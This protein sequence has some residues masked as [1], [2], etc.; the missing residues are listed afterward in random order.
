ME[1]I[2]AYSLHPV[3]GRD[4]LASLISQKMERPPPAPIQKFSTFSSS[5]ESFVLNCKNIS[6]IFV[7]TRGT[8]RHL[9]GT[10]AKSG[11]Q[12]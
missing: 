7:V 12:A 3:T 9:V 6:F 8:K 11:V 10:R 4:S 2:P 5:K 1:R